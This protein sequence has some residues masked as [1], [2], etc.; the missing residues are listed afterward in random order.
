M[1]MWAT[2]ISCD[3]HTNDIYQYTKTSD[4]VI[5]ATWVIH[6]IKKEHIKKNAV[7]IDV[8]FEVKDWKIYWDYDFDWIIKT[9]AKITPVPGW[10][11]AMT[12]SMLMKNTLKAFKNKENNHE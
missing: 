10:V 7:I 12:V 5:S 2:V 11:W 6:L 3:Q 4:I 1:N 9:W 8:W